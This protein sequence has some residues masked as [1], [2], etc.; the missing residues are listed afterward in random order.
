[1]RGTAT[2]MHDEEP[3]EYDPA[4]EWDFCQPATCP[5]H[6]PTLAVPANCS[7]SGWHCLLCVLASAGTELDAVLFGAGCHPSAA[8]HLLEAELA[9][10][11]AAGLAPSENEQTR[12]PLTPSIV[13]GE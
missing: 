11:H 12:L 3:L 7:L 10:E 6:G 4:G 13:E 9:S 1:M 5:V 2:E 8:S